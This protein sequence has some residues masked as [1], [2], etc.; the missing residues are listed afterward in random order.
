M[1]LT[2]SS[3]IPA[4][5][6]ERFRA[7]EMTGIKI[8]EL[9]KKRCYCKRHNN[10]ELLENAAKIMVATGGSHKYFHPSLGNSTRDRDRRR[11]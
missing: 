10:K 2:G 11:L 4:T 7:G 3:L 1:S 8:V 5:A 9:V 6:S